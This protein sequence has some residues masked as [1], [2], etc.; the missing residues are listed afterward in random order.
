MQAVADATAVSWSHRSRA[1]KVDI[2]GVNID[3]MDLQHTVEAVCHTIRSRQ[4]TFIVVPNVFIVTECKRDPEYHNIINSAD[5][6]FADGM[7]LVWT[8]YL[9]GQYSG[10]RVSGAD[11]FSLFQPIS[12]KEGFSSFY[13]GGGPG[14]SERVAENFRKQYPRLRIV[15]NYSPPLGEISEAANEDIVTRINAASP[16][17]LWVGLGA[18]RQEKWIYRNLHRLQVTVAIG[19]GAAFDYESGKKKR[20]PRWMRQLGLEWSYRILFENPSLF[21]RKR[22]YAYLWEFVFPVLGEIARQRLLARKRQIHP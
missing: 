22:H 9:L 16:D 1:G 5:I 11:F 20:A 8:S 3:R 12:E 13:L 19:V 15:G 4:K 6:A 2:L 21:W 10:G 7:P 18:P 14:G 17:I